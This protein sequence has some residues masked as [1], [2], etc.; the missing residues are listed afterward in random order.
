M[1][2]LQIN[3]FEQIGAQSEDF[4]FVF[5]LKS[6]NFRY[7]NG[8]FQKIWQLPSEP[9]LI[10]PSSILDTIHKD[11]KKDV[12]EFCKAFREHKRHG[13][14]D[15]RI[16]LAG[17]PELWASLT[18]YFIES[19]KDSFF[20]AGIVANESA[21]KRNEF[22][23]LKINAKKN[24]MLEILSHDLT[25][26][27]GMVQMMAS[28]IQKSVKEEDNDRIVTWSTLIQDICK[29]NIKL[30]RDLVN[31]EFLESSEIDLILERV[32]LVWEIGETINTYKNAETDML[33]RFIFNSSEDKLYVR[34]DSLKFLQVINNL[35]SNAI[36]FTRDHG[37]ITIEL[38]KKEGFF[39]VTVED[40]G[41]GIP[42]KY[43]PSLF[44]KFTP[45]RR[46]GLKGEETT[47][48]GM[49][50]IDLIVKLHKGKV[51]CES[52]EGVGSK[53]F[54]EIPDPHPSLKN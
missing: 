8:S 19:D 38:K 21:R 13:K 17:Q 40:D 46:K 45:A 22:Q 28:A 27:I 42:E 47:G 53:F 25:G 16:L 48:L 29:R 30:I 41:V 36:K 24:A 34:I 51:W 43:L 10:K 33:K 54:V 26:P 15:F 9:F 11:D 14:I 31:Q 20:A 6:L 37:T 35:I 50:T 49:S 32:D 18:L 2:T 4:L 23:M 39:I 52:K 1:D 44:D 7:L 5:D 3:V 12:Y